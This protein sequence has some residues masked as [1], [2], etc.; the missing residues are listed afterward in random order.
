MA[1]SFGKQLLSIVGA[2]IVMITA[3]ERAT[4]P[5]SFEPP[6]TSRHFIM[7]DS[8]T[9]KVYTPAPCPT[10]YGSLPEIHCDGWV[11][12]FSQSNINDLW[13]VVD[14][15][16]CP[17]MRDLLT[18]MMQHGYINKV[19]MWGATGNPGYYGFS[20]RNLDIPWQS[21]T[22][23]DAWNSFTSYSALAITVRHEALHIL[24]PNW[25]LTEQQLDEEAANCGRH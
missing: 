5:T 23:L 18:R 9:T 20:H 21:Y 2:S 19:D 12:E 3:C 22:H 17:G 6:S 15:S 14:E 8:D 13:D 4:A 1:P 25:Q 11:R 24:H 10:Q 7:P 16:T